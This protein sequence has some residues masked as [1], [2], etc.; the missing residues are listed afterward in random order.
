MEEDMKRAFMRGLNPFPMAVPLDATTAA[1]G[2]A[3]AQQV[4][5]SNSCSDVDAQHVAAPKVEHVVVSRSS[6][7]SRW[8]DGRSARARA[9]RN[10]TV[11]TRALNT[12]LLR[13]AAIALVSPVEAPDSILVSA[14]AWLV[15]AV[16][17]F[18]SFG[19]MTRAFFEAKSAI[20]RRLEGER[21]K[22]QDE[23]AKKQKIKDM[24]DRL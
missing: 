17:T 12:H 6:S 19:F 8:Q 1:S 9:A 16:A 11:S 4:L 2:L 23:D 18:A 20:D 22:E 13:E 14:T 10:L 24:F 3:T 7:S 5:T 21:L 15:V